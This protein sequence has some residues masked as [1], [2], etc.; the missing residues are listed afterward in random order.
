[1]S[2][3][4]AV[5]SAA[6]PCPL[7]RKILT[8]IANADFTEPSFLQCYSLITELMFATE[9]SFTSPISG[10]SLSQVSFKSSTAI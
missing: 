3:F 7:K 4:S 8:S 9:S 10:I 5:P 2:F 6:H 1:L